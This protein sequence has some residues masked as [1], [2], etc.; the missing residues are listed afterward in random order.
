MTRAGNEQPAEDAGWYEFLQRYRGFLQ[1]L[2][3]SLAWAVALVATNLFRYGF[4]IGPTF[5]GGFFVT[6]V[7]AVAFQVGIGFATELYRVRWSVGSFEETVLLGFTVVAT[8]FLMLAVDLIFLGHAV[9]TSAAVAAGAFTLLLIAG[10]RGFWRMLW[11]YRQRPTALSEPVI[12]FGAGDGGKQVLDVLNGNGSPYLPVALLDDHPS[13]Q[14]HRLRHL[15]VSGTRHQIASVA[16]RTRA[17]TLVVAI[18]SA[19][20]QL[21]RELSQFS[22]D[23]GLEMRVLPP[24]ARLFGPAVG[25]SDIRPVI[26]ADLLGRHPI[27]TEVESIAGYLE[28]K[29]VL[30]TGA[31]GSIGSEICRQVSRFGPERLVML[32]RDESLLHNVQLSIEGRATLDTRTLVVCDIRD[33]PALRAIFD[34]HSPEV[35]FHS[36]A[37]KHLPLLE[38]W[39]TEAIKTNVLGTL[40]V[41][42]ASKKAGTD[43]FVNIS[44]DKAADPC[45]VL[46]YTKRIGERLT[47]SMNERCDG[48]FLSVRFGNV[49]GSRGSVLETFRTQIVTGGPITV[50]HPDVTRYFMTV[51]EAVQ[52]VVQAGAIG[53]DGEVLVLDM[54]VPVR[55]ADIAKRLAKETEP[56]TDI[57]YTGLRLGEKLHETLFGNGEFDRRP[58]HPLVSHVKVPP[59]DPAALV[60]LNSTLD[61]SGQLQMLVTEVDAIPHGRNSDIAN[62]CMTDFVRQ[63][64]TSGAET[65]V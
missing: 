51:E 33:E 41:L 18:P 12:V 44:T 40:N 24:A 60:S 49:L 34:E 46:G 32:D 5:V 17:T 63:P 30:V 28:G 19:D 54:G 26:E 25:I 11:E 55:I 59:L 50:T 65:D 37:L 48:A 1:P 47:A 62:S 43:R 42:E 10:I 64:Q 45:S 56:A 8:T 15:R 53:S 13:K 2:V 36:A 3:D 20:S 31:G 57:V 6:L 7:V 16:R 27:D 38:M 29:R 35:V 52:L 9:P 4:H 58:I 21:F 61:I 39:P 22:R 14:N 23:A